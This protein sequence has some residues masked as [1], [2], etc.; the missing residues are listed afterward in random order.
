M[1]GYPGNPST[2]GLNDIDCNIFS[3]TGSAFDFGN[4]SE[5]VRYAVG[6]GSGSPTYVDT[7]DYVEILTTGNAVDFGNLVRGASRCYGAFSNAHGG[8]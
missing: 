2:A 3:S 4:L 5:A 7:I 6:G 1:G 8:L